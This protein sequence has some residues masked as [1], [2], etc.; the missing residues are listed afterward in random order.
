[1]FDMGN[2]IC[3]GNF[4]ITCN[5]LSLELSATFHLASLPQTPGEAL[6]GS[7]GTRLSAGWALLFKK[8]DERQGL[9]IG[10]P[11][12]FKGKNIGNC[13]GSLEKNGY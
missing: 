1:M 9:H 4:H 10:L 3:I 6:A 8:T 7:Q 2:F 5:S 11:Q 13:F 12:G